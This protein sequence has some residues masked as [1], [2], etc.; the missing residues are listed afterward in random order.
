MLA[1][2][3]LPVEFVLNGQICDAHL[4]IHHKVVRIR[5]RDAF[6]RQAQYV[7][8]RLKSDV[9]MLGCIIFLSYPQIN[10]LSSDD[11]LDFQ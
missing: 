1:M 5:A 7:I 9:S 3:D 6:S 4:E 8:N 2:D 10:G 11:K